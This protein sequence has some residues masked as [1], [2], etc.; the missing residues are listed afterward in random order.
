MRIPPIP[1]PKLE[2]RLELLQALG[3]GEIHTRRLAGRVGKAE[4]SVRNMMNAMERDG[5][6]VSRSVPVEGFMRRL[7]MWKATGKPL[8]AHPAAVERRAVREKVTGPVWSCD[9]L[10]MALGVKR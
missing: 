4:G 7:R 3:D 1:V 5:L 9:A 8:P 6:V 2:P 10:T